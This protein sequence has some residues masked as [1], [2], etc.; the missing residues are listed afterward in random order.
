M[1]SIVKNER[2]NLVSALGLNIWS[3]QLTQIMNS[4]A[5]TWSLAKQLYSIRGRYAIIPFSSV[6]GFVATSIQ[7]ALHK[8]GIGDL[9]SRPMC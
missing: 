3:G 6:I 5:V 7:Y 8:V 9:P 2:V 4:E 1:I